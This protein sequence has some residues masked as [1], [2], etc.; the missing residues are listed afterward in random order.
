MRYFPNSFLPTSS[1]STT[2]VP[3]NTTRNA[4]SNCGLNS[5][6]LTAGPIIPFPPASGIGPGFS[7]ER[8]RKVSLPSF[9]SF[10]Y[11]IASVA[12]PSSS[13]TT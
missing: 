3:P 7:F 9:W 1:D 2:M 8:G 12:T 4:G 13:T 6:I 10:R 5:S 11:R